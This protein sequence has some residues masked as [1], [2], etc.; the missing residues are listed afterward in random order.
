[1][2][3]LSHQRL[4]QRPVHPETSQSV[5]EADE[6]LDLVLRQRAA[7]AVGTLT[8]MRDRVNGVAHRALEGIAPLSHDPAIL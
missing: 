8:Q 6:R 5:D 7:Q 4:R 2:L 1:M 3:R